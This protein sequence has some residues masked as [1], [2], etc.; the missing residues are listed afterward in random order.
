[1]RELKHQVGKK[2]QIWSLRKL[3]NHFAEHGL[4]DL[5]P[6]VVSFS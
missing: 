6:D 5:M 1:M 2:R 3:V 4:V